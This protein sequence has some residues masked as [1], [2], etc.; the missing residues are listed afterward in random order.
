MAAP[1]SDSLR[2]SALRELTARGYF[3]Q[4]SDLEA[5]DHSLAEG[6][7][8]VYVGYDP[9]ADSL[10]IGHLLTIMALR[11]LQRHGH[12]PLCLLGGGTALVGDPS[13]RTE[14]RRMLDR[15]T[16]AAN[17]A[18]FK[19]QIA[20]FVHFDH[21]V[22]HDAL[23]LDN[24][25]WLLELG[26]LQFLRDIGRHFTVNRMI[27]AKTYRER[28][29]GELPLSFLEFNYQLLQAYDFMYLHREH[30]CTLQLGGADQ[31][32]NMIAGVE[33]IRRMAAHDSG[34][35]R[36]GES[37]AVQC[38]TL[39]LLTTPDGRKMGKTERGALWLDPSKVS[40]FDYYQYWINCNDAMVGQLL[41]LF[42]EIPLPEI[43]EL[44][45]TEGAALRE[46]KRRLAHEATS[47]L[48]G[49][50]AATNAET[51]SRQAFGGG[52]DW[53]AVSCVTVPGPE[54]KLI[55]LV[56]HEDLAAFRSKRDARQRIESGAVKLDGEPCTDPN[57]V[58]AAAD[59]GE[60]GLR[61][62]A[63]KRT[64]FRVVLS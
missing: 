47:L 21:G 59:C 11:V 14:T 29:E 36:D 3:E 46:A 20:S 23:M 7:V 64:R 19:R 62:Q 8:T 56:V 44:T 41:R 17:G 34:G 22:P 27:A 42:T 60:T 33:L 13:G 9:T 24:S 38:L 4:A 37:D 30:A 15:E 61:L 28:L 39:P 57:Y 51:A 18:A 63:G 25:T 40:A 26:Y 6:M 53:S 50:E 52:D 54:I 55:D 32:G 1:P 5:L 31:W 16:I 45:A 49:S 35:E 43:A 48:H 10:H 58:I 12:R 2:S